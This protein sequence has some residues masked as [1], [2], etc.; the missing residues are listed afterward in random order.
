MAITDAQKKQL[1]NM[2]ISA[3]KATLGD[4]IQNLQNAIITGTYTAV[5]ADQTATTVSIPVGKTVTGFVV[6]ILRAGKDV[7]NK[8]ALSA[9]TTNLVVATNS[10]DYI[11]TTGDI[12]NFIVF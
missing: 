6:N 7:T 5:S 2:C 1:N 8:A 12:I 4:A 11:L 9:S 3:N 10:T